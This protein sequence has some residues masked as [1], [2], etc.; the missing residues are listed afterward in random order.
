M[1]TDWWGRVLEAAMLGCWASLVCSLVFVLVR[2]LAAPARDVLLDDDG[3]D[4][5]DD[6][7]ATWPPAETDDAR[8]RR[9]ACERDELVHRAVRGGRR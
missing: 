8:R 1:T 7:R 2:W 5:V 3:R 6:D 4:L 9:L